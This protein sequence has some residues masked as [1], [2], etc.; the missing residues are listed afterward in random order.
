MA[1][2]AKTAQKKIPERQCMGCNEKKPK[3]EL[4][5]V[6]RTASGTAELD[7]TGKKSGRGA[8]ICPCEACFK[9]ARKSGRI[10]RVLECEIPEEVYAALEEEV[11]NAEKGNGE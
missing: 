9:K 11:R 8:Y 7:F 3:K 2:Q 4:I 6:V 10:A 1:A 5:R